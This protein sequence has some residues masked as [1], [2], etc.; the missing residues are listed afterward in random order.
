MGAISCAYP[1]NQNPLFMRSPFHGLLFLAALVFCLRS[2]AQPYGLTQRPDV[3]PFLN[4]ILPET[5]ATVSGNW[6]A[7]PAFPNLYFTNAIGLAAVPG[8]NFLCVWEREGRAW[9]FVNNPNVTQKTLIL[10]ISNQCQGWDDSGLLGLAFHPG[11]I[12][13]RYMFVYYTWVV[14]G[15]VQG[16]QNSRPPTT[17]TGAYHD[18][19]SRFTLDANG[20]AIP[21]SELV[22]VDQIGNSVWHNG[23]GL[24]FHPDNG[25]L[26]W[27]D[28]DDA[29]GS[30]NQIITR[31][32]FSGVF[33]IDV[34]Q[35]GGSISH[36][37]VKQPLNGLTANYFIPNDNPFIGQ[38]NVLEEFFC[39]GLRS[40]HRMTIDPPSGRIFIGDVGEGSREEID[41]IELGE[42][43]LNFQ[44]NR[45]EGL[46]GD[47]VPP[48]PGINRRPVLDYNHSEGF[49][50]IGGYVYRG[51]EFAADLGGRYIFGD[52]GSR[53]IW[54][55]DE[56]T[57]PAGKTALCVV[58][59]GAGPNSGNDYTGLSSFGLDANNELYMC[60]MSSVGGRIYK[61]A[62][63]GPPPT[64]RPLPTLLSGA[65]AFTDLATLSPTNG[66]VPYTVNSPLWSDAAVKTRWVAVP[67]NASITFSPTGEWT[68]PSGTVF[69]KHFALATN[70]TNP[71]LLKRLET[72]LLVR[73]TNG[74]VYGASYKWRTDNSD[75]DLVAT[76]INEDI[77]ITTSTGTRT[78]QW[79][80]PGQQDCLRCHTVASG[81]VLGVNT[82]QLNGD[83]QYPA[84]G[85][86]DNQLRAWN[87]I[88][89][90][91][92][93]LNEA[94]ISTFTKTVPVTDTNAALEV[95][96]RSYL[97]A[98]CA[99]C[100][101]PS[102]VPSFFDARFDTPLDGQGLINGSV[103]N[104]LGIPGAKVVVAGDLS[105]SVLYQRD[106]SLAAIKM[107]PLAK[108]MIDAD[109]MAVLAQWINALPLPTPLTVTATAT[110]AAPGAAPQLVQFAAQAV[111]GNVGGPPADT[112][113][114]SKGT[115]A[116]QGENLGFGEGA[117]QAF[118]NSSATKWLDFANA[119]PAT[120]ASWIQYR[121]TNGLG[122]AV[123]QY[124]VTSA[125]DAPERDPGDWRLLGSN[126]NGTNWTTL[127]IRTNQVFANRFEPRSFSFTNNSAY[128]LYRFQIDRVA[129]PA[130]AN[131]VQLSELELIGSPVYS[132]AWA[133][134][135]GATS[136]LQN[137]A[138]TYTSNGI[139]TVT[140]VAADDGSVTTN[141][142]LVMVGLPS[143]FAVKVNFQT[144][145]TPTAPLGYLADSGAVFGARGNGFLY[146]WDI[147]NAVNARQ[148]NSGGS[149]DLRYDT[150]NHLQKPGGGTLWEIALPNGAYQ[151]RMIAGDPDNFDGTY[152]VALEEEL[153]L[154][155]QPTTTDRFF[156][157]IGSV[158][159]SDGRLSVGNYLGSSNNKI[160]FLEIAA[161][162]TAAPTW[163]LGSA[164]I[165]NGGFHLTLQGTNSIYYVIEAATNL[166]A[167]T[168]IFTNVTTSNLLEFL[169]PYATNFPVRF[170]RAREQ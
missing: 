134:G 17:I 147:D 2:T 25:F 61:L 13:N 45:I 109:A 76:M 140:I 55:L 138:T 18:R 110:P 107:P 9:T 15:T 151:V 62:R 83:F 52:N 126:N 64:S 50:V 42:S 78:Q 58:P 129:N 67:T 127:D 121:Y 36:P 57:V 101:R 65:G 28:G 69:V 105:K 169:D 14:P 34:D 155:A 128:N 81:G 6:S 122:Y 41:I 156:E 135:N 30:N 139:Y 112:T 162:P 24:F 93:P 26:Y 22:L 37:I 106:N 102:G 77:L 49:A 5:A 100:H 27:T 70:D 148:R 80:Y 133:F 29:A 10:N 165:T 97:D 48:Y 11:F 167:W 120:R 66:L 96:V 23:G 88:G 21:N 160:N 4:H 32:L 91:D 51:S 111:G 108:N 98:N 152:R 95:R 114:D 38:A 75:A 131:S 104:T 161:L 1:T 149:P 118:D 89:I 154:D 141:S 116:A 54:T 117:A 3:A 47:L 71:N 164:Q 35:R 53:V 74:T 19:L 125:N 150:F 16:N 44:W 143:N 166:T 130:T 46:N 68:F 85:N 56:T 144:P 123:N 12:T 145:T 72:R 124:S 90:F 7:V 92:A 86:T 146:G 59:K 84:S 33:R 159:V 113:D 63:S 168:P 82:R 99:H 73:D 79:S 39:L 8:T 132:Y 87:H 119:N 157:S 136:S 20:V 40:P 103:V 60:Q 137:P 31:N 158:L 94:T 163:L 153:F 170:Y 142:L 115:S 43:A